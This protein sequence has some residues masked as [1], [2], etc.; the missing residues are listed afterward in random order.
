MKIKI[1]LASLLLFSKLSFA[2]KSA[3]IAGD[4]S[5]LIDLLNKDY[6]YLNE[7][8]YKDLARDQKRV[9]KIFKTYLKDSSQ[10]NEKDTNLA[11]IG[12]IKD[13]F[14]ELNDELQN[15]K[16]LLKNT[17]KK[18]ELLKSVNQIKVKLSKLQL[19]KNLKFFCCK[20]TSI[21]NSYLNEVICL[22]NKKYKAILSNENDDYIT[23]NS[24]SSIQKSIPFIGS[25]T[26]ETFIDG[27]SKFL[28]KRVKAELSNYVIENIKTELENPKPYSLLNE[29]KIVLP[30]TISYINHFEAEEVLNFTNN[31]KQYIENDLNKLLVNAYNLKTTPRF[32]TL[33]NNNPDLELAFEALNILPQLSKIKN[34]IDYFDLLEQNKTL[35]KW[36]NTANTNAN[37]QQKSNI[38]NSIKLAN[39]LAH[40]LTIVDNGE[41]KFVSTDFMSSYG[42][43]PEF[44]LIY[45]GFLHE[46]NKNYYNIKIKDSS[47]AIDSLFNRIKA[48]KVM[49]FDNK[50]KAVQTNLS[51]IVKNAEKIY[52]EAKKIKKINK[53]EEKEITP[54]LI[55]NFLNDFVE[56]LEQITITGDF[57]VK[58]T[59]GQQDSN[60]NNSLSP[61]LNTAK[62]VNNIVLDLQKKRFATAI[63]KT[64]EIPS[65]FSSNK[66]SLEEILK[67]PEEANNIPTLYYTKQVL[68]KYKEKP[69]NN[70]ELNNL[71]QIL[72]LY[73]D[74]LDDNNL[75][76][77]INSFYFSLDALK[78]KKAYK[79][80]ITKIKNDLIQEGIIDSLVLPLVD[81]FDKKT[82]H[83]FKDLKPELINYFVKYTKN[84]LNLSQEDLTEAKKTLLTK[85]KTKIPSIAITTLNIKNKNAIKIIHFLGD[86]AESNNSEEVEKAFES[87]ALPTGSYSIKRNAFS[88]SINSYPGIF[89]GVDFSE[90]NSKA[91]TGITAPIGLST[92]TFI[93]GIHF[94]VPIIDIAA[95][96]RFRFDND[97]NTETISDF[98]FENIFSP[99]AFLIV[100]LGKSPFVFS[101][102]VQYGPQLKFTEKALMNESI[103]DLQK[104][105]WNVRA[106]IS[107]DIPIINLYHRPKK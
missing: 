101:T 90:Y 45:F 46:Q 62:N 85:L 2:Q 33:I 20:K 16:S 10:C 50:I 74:S 4:A 9:I 102:G 55:H 80:Q 7:N 98:N 104:N 26:F 47:L 78:N 37:Y 64:I 87:F 32:Q 65:N 79:V 77:T 51:S 48:E 19:K 52:Q 67:L 103:F 15:L 86:I 91:M 75:K 39:L 66:I 88:V 41:L 61:Y 63:I 69:K 71:K 99:G 13:N 106:G 14:F 76:S 25:L 68:T 36:S 72:A 54:E 1:L 82:S 107:I 17:E 49:N 18:D 59:F 8:F 92:T 31:V 84:N 21:G 95:P 23:Y 11:L 100:P 5:I 38:I 29:L 93:K 27:L 22:F 96:F 3:P 40:S 81:I 70:E 89:G 30:E 97:N 12:E 28:V 73:S 35:I 43:K 57:L 34:P 56:F 53:D 58:D 6:D 83:K 44:F 24:T 42:T 105:S 60:L 94:F